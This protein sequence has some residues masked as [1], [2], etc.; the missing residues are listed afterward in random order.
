[1]SAGSRPPRIATV[2]FQ[3][4]GNVGDEAILTG[5]ERLLDGTG[6]TVVTVFSGPEPVSIAA[7][8]DAARAVTW[9][10]LPTLRAL[11]ALRGV[12][13]LILAGGGLF[14]DHWAAVIPRY[15]AWTLAGRI[16]GARVAWIG[17]GVGPVRRSWLRR[18]LRIGARMAH[19]VTVRDQGSARVL[20]PSVTAA[21]VPDPSIFCEVPR[22]GSPD[23]I[24]IVVRA[25]VPAQRE[26]AA[27]LLRSL[28][29]LIGH[30]TA[31]GRGVRVLS[32]GGRA[33]ADFVA[34]LRDA[35]R[36]REGVSLAPLGPA[37]VD[38]LDMLAGLE[39][40]VTLRLHGLLLAALAGVPVVP[41]AY[42]PKVDAAAERLGLADLVVPLGDIGAERILAALDAAGEEARRRTVADAVR[43]LRAERSA[44]VSA[45]VGPEGRE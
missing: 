39:G 7:F 40:V 30:L 25:P 22:R 38:A 43:E 6:A 2:G 19:V 37:P 35:L 23:G 11:R 14:N 12:D 4:F 8:P 33:D 45:I 28:V 42:D 32:M 44:L 31:R 5:I 1:M 29:E 17:V 26:R 13:R 16:A 3:G 9:K 27:T 20:G 36:G 15:L 41:I 10:H 24:G 18:S 21:V 34:A